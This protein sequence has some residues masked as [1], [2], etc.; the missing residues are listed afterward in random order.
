[1]NTRRDF[2]QKLTASVFALQ[3]SPG[4]GIAEFNDLHNTPYDGPVLKVAIM[5]LRQLWKSCGR[6]NAGM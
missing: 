2:L 5:G 6:S 1:M 4:K 3:L